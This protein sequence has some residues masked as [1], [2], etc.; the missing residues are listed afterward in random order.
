VIGDRGGE[1]WEYPFQ[2][3]KIDL[4][5]GDGYMI[6]RRRDSGRDHC[7]DGTSQLRQVLGHQIR[8]DSLQPGH[9][10]AEQFPSLQKREAGP[11]RKVR[12]FL[13]S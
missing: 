1:G 9:V 2:P 8:K 4:A 7:A 5:C 10:I 3:A 11:G 6:W 12:P 13:V